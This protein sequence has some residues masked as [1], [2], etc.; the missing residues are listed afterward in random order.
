LISHRFLSSSGDRRGRRERSCPPEADNTFG[1]VSF[2]DHAVTD[3]RDSARI[4]AGNSE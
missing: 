2:K 1:K 4:S 3:W